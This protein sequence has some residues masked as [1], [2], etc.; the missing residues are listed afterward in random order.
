MP[1]DANR[2]NED[3]DD[4]TGDGAVPPRQQRSAI[5]DELLSLTPPDDGSDNDVAGGALGRH[6]TRLGEIVADLLG[7]A[8]A[9]RGARRPTLRESLGC[10]DLPS[11]AAS[12]LASCL[13]RLMSSRG[14]SLDDDGINDDDDA[15]VGGGVATSSVSPLSLDSALLYAELIGTEG[16]WGAGMIDA[17][18]MIAIRGVV[19]GW[20]ATCCSRVAVATGRGGRGRG[21][22]PE[23]KRSKAV[24]ATATKIGKTAG[25]GGGMPPSRRSARIGEMSTDGGGE[26]DGDD[27]GNDGDV[28]DNDVANEDDD[29]DGG[30][31]HRGAIAMGPSLAAAL[32]RAS[33]HADYVNWPEDAREFYV[34]AAC[35]A[36]GMM[37]ALSSRGCRAGFDH[38]DDDDDDGD[39]AVACREAASWLE[40]ALRSTV[41]PPPSPAPR[42]DTSPPD[43]PTPSSAR[44]RERSASGPRTG[45]RR[46]VGGRGGGGAPRST[47][48][49]PPGEERSREAG[50]HLLRGLLPLFHL[51]TEVPN[52]QAGK[53]AALEAASALLVG[54]VAS[55]S[56]DVVV[57]V[58]AIDDPGG[59]TPRVAVG[60]GDSAT[61]KRG[62]RKSVGFSYTPGGGRESASPSPNA[63]A[64]MMIA[65]PSLKKSVTP[66]RITTRSG[67]SSSSSSSSAQPDVR[68]HPVLALVVGLLQRLL[69]TGGLERADAR[70]RACLLGVRC[71]THLP[72]PE[73]CDLLR[74]VGDMCESKVSCHRLLGVELIGEVMCQ[75]WFW[76]DAERGGVALRAFA[77]SSSIGEGAREDA[78]GEGGGVVRAS[79]GGSSIASSRLLA[80][81]QGRLSDKSP[82]VRTRASLSLGEMA[83]KAS[84][85]REEGRNLDGTIIAGVTGRPTT[86]ESVPSRALALALCRIG[87]S[88]VD[89]LRR[90]ASTDYSATVRKS[91]IVAWLQLLKLAHRER[92]GEFVVSGP[93]I[94]ALCR[95]CNDA[96]VATRKAAADAL[97]KLVQANNDGEEHAA[98]AFS[99][100]VAWV[101]GVLPLVADAE[102]TCVMKA[103][104]F[105]SVLV[106]EPII[107][108]DDGLENRVA[109]RIMSKLSGGLNRAGAS[110]NA[111]GSLILALQKVL[112]NAGK[113]SNILSRNLLRAVYHAIGISLGLDDRRMSLDSTM[114]HENES[115]WD[116]FEVNTT[117]MRTGAWCLLD[118]LTSCLISNDTGSAKS[119]SLANIS[120]RQAVGASQIDVSF[121]ASSLRKLRGLMTSEDVSSDKKIKLIATSRHCLKVIAKMGN[122]VPL[123]DAEACFLELYSDLESFTIPID[124]ISATVNALIT[125]TKRMCDD[126]RKDVSG[127]VR[128]W[129]NGLLDRCEHAIESH[130]SVMLQRGMIIDDDE[131]LLSNVLYFIGELSLVGFTSQEESSLLSTKKRNDITPSDR[132]PVR[133]LLIRPSARLAH[134]VKLML[135]NTMPMPCAADYELTPTPV[136]IRAHSFITLGKLCLRDESLAKESLNILA[137]ELHKDSDSD[138]AVQSNCLMVMGDLCVRYTNLVD[139]YLPFMAAS[140]Q[141]GD[142]K[143]VEVNTSSRLSLSFS[144]KFYAYSMVKKNAIML[145]SSL[146]LQD[147]IKWRGLLIHRFLAA[148]ADEDDE[149]SQLAQTALRGP[150]LQKQPSLFANHFVGAVFVFNMCKAHPI[151][152]AEASSG[153]SGLTVDFEET[154]LAGSIGYHKRREVYEVMLANMNDEQKLEVTARLVKEVLG[155][156]LETSGDLSAVC[157]YPTVNIKSST[158]LSDGRIEAATNVLTDTLAVL[159]SPQIKVGRKGAED[160]EDDLSSLNGSRL[161]QRNAH[162]QRL[163]TRISRKHLMEIV[164][165]ILCNLKS[166]L[167][168]SHSPLLKNTMKYLGYIFRSYKSEVQEYLANQP[169]LLQELQYDTRQYEKKQKQRSRV[170]V[171]PSEIVMDEHA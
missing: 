140:L 31:A 87:T 122:F 47:G 6:R 98:H 24:A 65:P 88:L 34:E 161:D 90:R 16:A 19:R 97:T 89:A 12:G 54:V 94:S 42:D 95:L 27:G 36:L 116:L 44:S 99:L 72:V 10:D 102:A 52:G 168:S 81:L 113:D 55:I 80:C 8:I 38:H 132:E 143:P 117:E 62:G 25:G 144:R 165:P 134:L 92:R 4:A 112:I 158:K 40:R 128:G 59:R 5:I 48:R 148:V 153:G 15:G 123:D 77:P 170:S 133:G 105:F 61:P 155:G 152:T 126:S 136:G 22:P 124:I 13:A 53:L 154:S 137:R 163:L 118:A 57:V 2:M 96:S 49:A 11:S 93:D 150:L 109:W 164:I 35:A 142:G 58:A 127:E 149:V 139:K 145:L 68:R 108:L 66:R 130:L 7:G 3:D 159:T 141:A 79:S 146:L 151:Y 43:G 101:W 26:Y 39:F 103:V 21:R 23:R 75:G 162:K 115:E 32:G 69:T 129:V 63:A 30:R 1:N 70:S 166:L 74:F 84:A 167:E 82:T 78:G 17:G 125:L 119:P 64:T 160:A 9:A 91:S 169:T 18:G 51:R 100:E 86:D 50:I 106:I 147:Y 41:L 83:R 29:N 111:S 56:E 120:L 76:R 104:E 20:C 121:L 60:A 156:S 114:S 46:G 67:S 157:K 110:R 171:L 85:A 71:M 45:R 37:S 33:H 73:R 28:N 107:E 135:P 138:P 14:W 131:R